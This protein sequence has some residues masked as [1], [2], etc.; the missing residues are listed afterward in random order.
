MGEH[1]HEM[2]FCIINSGF[3]ETVM[4]AAKEAG[5]RGGTVMSGHG[6]ANKEA[7]E[8]FG[9]PI[10]SDKEILMIIVK[11]ELK[12]DVL[13]AIYK[14]AGV[15]SPSRGIVFSLPVSA[16]AGIKD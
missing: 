13:S 9:I 1:T 5:A 15:D 4:D 6:T 10:Q 16:T 7:E 11:K 14:V 12:D 3:S 2:V 8:K